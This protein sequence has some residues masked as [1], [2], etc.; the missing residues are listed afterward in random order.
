MSARGN[1]W[2]CRRDITGNKG[3]GRVMSICWRFEMSIDRGI[4]DDDHKFLIRC[5]NRF[6][7]TVTQTHRFSELPELLT[8]LKRYALVH[9]EREEELQRCIHYPFQ[10]AHRREH[11]DMVAQL[12]E[13][14]A[15]FGHQLAIDPSQAVAAM[16]TLLRRWL[17]DH[18]LKTD[19][20]MRPYVRDMA[21]FGSKMAPLTSLSSHERIEALF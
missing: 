10:D 11:Q 9:F 19:L 14:E 15:L 12:M 20:Q 4:I 1:R 3:Q 13:T 16:G 8:G 17:V 18:I 21:M 6:L 2:C 5:V 7:E